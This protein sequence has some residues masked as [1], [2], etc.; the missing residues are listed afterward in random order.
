MKN[1][2]FF[3]LLFQFENFHKLIA[4]PVDFLNERPDTYHF[5]LRTLMNSNN[6]FSMNPNYGKI[7]I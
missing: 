2:E 7:I 4:S 6:D 1:R 3:D 5:F